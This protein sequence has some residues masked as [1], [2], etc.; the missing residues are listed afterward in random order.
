MGNHIRIT[1]IVGSYRKGGIIDTAIDEILASA[2]EEGA[3]VEKIYLIDKHIEF[4]TNCRTCTQQDGERRGQCVIADDISTV[5]DEIERSDAIVL[6]S[7]MNFGTVTAVMKK[8]IERLVCFAWWPWG[9]NAPKVPRKQKEKRAVVV[10]SSA[11]PALMGRLMTKIVSL[12]KDASSLLGA[13]TIGVLFI[14]FAATEQQ[15]QIGKQTKKKARR[16]GKKL[17][18]SN[19]VQAL[20]VI[21][22]Y[23][24]KEIL[25]NYRR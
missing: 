9:M 16:L 6:G 14:G 19:L 15:Q 17:V 7:P 10:A 4:C 23:R 11:A 25:C 24:E 20:A 21:Q 5:L 13:R 18:S 1:A 3:E 12:L 22:Q 8:F 2:R